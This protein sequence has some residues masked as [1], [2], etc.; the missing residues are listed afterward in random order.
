MADR[1]MSSQITHVWVFNGEQSHL[2]NAVFLSLELAETGIKKKG[3]S[4]ILT[5]YPINTSVYEWAIQNGVFRPKPSYQNL[6][7]FIQRF[8]SASLEHYHYENG[9]NCDDSDSNER[10]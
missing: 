4:G 5:A 2:P 6:P 7:E 10:A 3:V 8:T 9:K 1:S